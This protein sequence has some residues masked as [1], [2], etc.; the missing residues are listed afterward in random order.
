MPL[1]F[2]IKSAVVN[3]LTLHDLNSLIYNI[4]CW[5]LLSSSTLKLWVLKCHQMNNDF[6][7]I[8][9]PML[10][11]RNNTSLI[12][13]YNIPEVNLIGPKYLDVHFL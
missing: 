8:N 2:L 3:K 13:L 10:R 11:C 12:K 1:V 9:C 5:N 7:G 4:S 6:S